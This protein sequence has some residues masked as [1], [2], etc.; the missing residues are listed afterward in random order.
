MWMHNAGWR[1][2]IGESDI[3]VHVCD[4]N[5]INTSSWGN[6]CSHILLYRI[7]LSFKLESFAKTHKLWMLGNEIL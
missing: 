1:T 4:Y 5:L 7:S 3:N 2:T 6:Q